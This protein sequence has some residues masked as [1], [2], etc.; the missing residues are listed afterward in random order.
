MV[1]LNLWGEPLHNGG[2]LFKIG[3]NVAATDQ[4][5]GGSRCCPGRESG[6]WLVDKASGTERPEQP[7][8]PRSPSY[9]RVMH[10]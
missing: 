1:K 10:S 7:P 4:L 2:D 6:R 3:V 8:D 9:H 5:N